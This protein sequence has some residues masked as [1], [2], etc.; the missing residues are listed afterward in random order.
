MLL[1]LS[2]TT[3]CCSEP[4]RW[5]E[6]RKRKRG[7]TET[8]LQIY[9][10]KNATRSNKKPS[11]T[12]PFS[13]RSSWHIKTST[14]LCLLHKLGWKQQNRK[15]R[16]DWWKFLGEVMLKKKKSCVCTWC[17]AVP[18]CG[19]N[20]FHILVW[21]VIPFSICTATCCSANVTQRCEQPDLGTVCVCVARWKTCTPE[22]S[23]SSLSVKRKE[24]KQW[25][26][27]NIWS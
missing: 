15:D 22:I 8:A 27:Q 2:S 3:I 10:C 11:E 19:T 21:R 17:E 1:A 12:P 18:Q 23:A 6:K 7:I 4:Q 24:I 16:L 26:E 14:L 20:R 13:A 9:I 5:K 25:C